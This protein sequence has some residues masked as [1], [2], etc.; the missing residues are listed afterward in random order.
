MGKQRSFVKN[1]IILFVAMFFSKAIGAVLKIP[2]TNMLGGIGMGYF[3]TA[4]SLFSPIYA[5]AAAGLPTIIS[6]L[7]AQDI[8]C[9]RY[10]SVRLLKRN[11]LK[12]GVIL[13]VAGT[14]AILLFAVPFSR[15]IAGSPD[16]L[17]S[18]L[19][20]APSV[21]FCCIAAV[22][23]GYYEG[24]CDMMP[25]AA[26]Q[27]VEAIVKAATGLILTSLVLW[28]FGE[29]ALPL[30]AAAAVL[31]VTL[32][33]F[34]G[35]AYLVIRNKRRGDGI[36]KSELENCEK[37]IKNTANRKISKIF[38]ETLPL[39]IGA[40]II[41]IGSF[42]DML[43][44]PNCINFSAAQNPEFF[45]RY[46]IYGR[47]SGIAIEDIG[48]FIYGSYSG[49]VSTLFM[50]IPAMTGLIPKSCLPNIAAAAEKC[51]ADGLAKN[52]ALLFKGTFTIG[53]PMCFILGT[54]AKPVLLLLY[55]SRRAEIAASELPLVLMCAG[56]IVI[57]VAGALFCV[58]QALGRSDLP[59]K[60]M[61]PASIIKLV[62]NL[63]LISVPE[64]NVAG[65]VIST[66]ISYF[67]VCITGAFC[68][69]KCTGIRLTIT[70]SLIKPLW[71]AIIAAIV[72]FISY[73]NLFNY[74]NLFL[75]LAFSATAG[76]VI[77]TISIALLNY[78]GKD[79]RLCKK[80][81]KTN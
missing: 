2:L 5:L 54:L 21:L 37:C 24:L 25:T 42:I 12:L 15:Y 29:N 4:Y 70:K 9:R 11:G 57:S 7:T 34:C 73:S 41:N 20:I 61:I 48:N 32:S 40:V 56:G 46:F 16:S 63:V 43:T 49:I 79:K 3:S 68:L 66:I 75:K 71:S 35:L 67:F 44:I 58:F 64:L 6:K 65:A 47:S 50:L 60:L 77:F 8:A 19:A 81:T 27:I 10:K 72:T 55:S 31:G 28:H 33:E 26:S 30:A 69:K 23:K 53:L 13:G 39:S 76:G 80:C 36:T 14:L 74:F 45:L 1:T 22:Y 62:L 52:I 51:D 59:I 17:F 38:I 18:I 78:S